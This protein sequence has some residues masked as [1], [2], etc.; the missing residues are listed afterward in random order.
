MSTTWVF[1][2]LLGGRELAMA[3]RRV[4]GRGWQVA[5]ALML[6]DVLAALIGLA[7]SLLIA[8]FVNED[9]RTQ[10]WGMFGG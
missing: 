6:R 4:S 10:V 7:V 9:F 1:L 3:L 5:V 2:G 8:Y